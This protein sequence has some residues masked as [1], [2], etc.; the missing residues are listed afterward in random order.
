MRS[1]LLLLPAALLVSCTNLIVPGEGQ[2]LGD[3]AQATRILKSSAEAHGNPWQ[4]YRT[5]T[6][7]FS[8]E[9]STIAA[10]V[11]PELVDANFRMSSVETYETRTGKVT[12]THTGPGGTKQV[13]RTSR[14][15]S[16]FYNGEKIEDGARKDASALVADAWRS[17]LF[18]SSWLVDSAADLKV[19]KRDKLNGAEHVLIQ[20]KIKPGFGFSSEDYFIAWIDPKTLYLDRLQFTINGLE[21]TQGADVDVVFSH[22]MKAKDGS[23]W[24]THFV[25]HVRRPIQIKAHEWKLDT[26]SADGRKLK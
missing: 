7:S 12:Q 6:A 8:G 9:W 22:F 21:S 19:L 10:R 14:D 1:L 26:L 2:P 24:P 5:V 4:K 11:Q 20:G 15:V 17:F 16:V 25:E 13:V 3:S 18:G 23:V